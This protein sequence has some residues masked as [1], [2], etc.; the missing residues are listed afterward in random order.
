MI[1]FNNYLIIP[2]N[3][4]L[5]RAQLVTKQPVLAS[6]VPIVPNFFLTINA[7]HHVHRNILPNPEHPIPA[8]VAVI[9]LITKTPVIAP[10]NLAPRPAFLVPPVP[11]V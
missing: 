5:A 7:R 8:K 9:F 1:A 6:P 11:F 4:A 3:Y 2:A 10:A